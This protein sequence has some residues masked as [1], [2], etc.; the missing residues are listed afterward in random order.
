M[1]NAIVNKMRDISNR[2]Y[3]VFSLS[4]TVCGKIWTSSPIPF[5]KAGEQV[6]SEEKK[7]V[8][9]ALYQRERYQAARKAVEEA[10]SQLNYCPVCKSLICDNCFMICDDIDMCIDCAK[11]LHESGEVVALSM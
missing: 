5:S 6:G 10:T 7:I 11:T 4:C 1:K 2:D 9:E 8:Y 3:F